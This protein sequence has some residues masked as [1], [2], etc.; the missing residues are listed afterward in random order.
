MGDQDSHPIGL[1]LT[2][3]QSLADCTR[4]RRRLAVAPEPPSPPPLALWAVPAYSWG[5]AEL[6]GPGRP[7]LEGEAPTARR[8]T[9][10]VEV[11]TQKWPSR[12]WRPCLPQGWALY[13]HVTGISPALNAAA[14]MPGPGTWWVYGNSDPLPESSRWGLR[15]AAGV[16]SPHLSHRA[17]TPPFL[18]SRPER[19]LSSPRRG[20]VG[21]PS[22]LCSVQHIL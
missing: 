15:D 18:G 9:V 21:L 17:G 4:E 14:N 8:A 7:R 22:G 13:T 1:L 11:V 3:F 5:S 12:W 16:V 19:P 6:R 20:V 10:L 2:W